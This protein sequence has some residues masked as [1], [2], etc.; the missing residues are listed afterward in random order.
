[1]ATRK[2]WGL[3]GNQLKLI[4]LALMTIDHVGAFLL[5]QYPVL[6][7]IGRP[8]MPIFAYM[9]A[10]GCHHTRNKGN[11]LLRLVFAALLTQLVQ[12]FLSSGLALYQ[13]VL[14]TFSFSLILVITM[15]YAFAHK[16]LSW[17]LPVGCGVGIWFICEKLGAYLPGFSVDYG[18]AGVLLPVVISLGRDRLARFWLTAGG[19]ALLCWYYGGVQWYAMGALVPLA[20][21]S[22][23]RGKAKL[24]WLFYLYFPAHLALIYILSDHLN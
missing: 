15:E 14:V 16:L 13:T 19:L 9:I 23:K 21:Y 5:P 12:Y 20:L 24:K 2:T 10:E 7:I 22:G 6:R 11:Y 17:L 3:S 4:A 8:A 1:M 18:F